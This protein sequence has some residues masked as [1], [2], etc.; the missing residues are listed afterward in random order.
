MKEVAEEDVV[1]Y[2]LCHEEDA[3]RSLSVFDEIDNI[4]SIVMY[5]NRR[6]KLSFKIINQ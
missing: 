1:T 4:N 6:K 3:S 2:F 5:Q